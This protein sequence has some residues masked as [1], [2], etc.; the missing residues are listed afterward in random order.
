MPNEIHKKETVAEAALDFG[1]SG[2]ELNSLPAGDICWCA[3]VT[4]M[5]D[6]EYAQVTLAINAGTATP[7]GTIEVYVGE[8]TGTLITADHHIVLSDHGNEGTATDVA[9]ILADLGSPYRVI[10]VTEQITYTFAFKIWQPGTSLTIFVYNNTD[11]A[12]AAS[13]HSAYIRGFLPEVQ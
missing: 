11:E 5:D 3:P 9:S 6:E 1:V 8:D 2:A 7:E 12:F 10:P 13:G 4:T